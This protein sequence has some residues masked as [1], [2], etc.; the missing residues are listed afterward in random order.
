MSFPRDVEKS[1]L[2]IPSKPTQSTGDYTLLSNKTKNVYDTKLSNKGSFFNERGRTMRDGGTDHLRGPSG[3]SAN[4]SSRQ[5]S[6]HMASKPKALG[7]ASPRSGSLPGLGATD[8]T[9]QPPAITSLASKVSK[10]S[11]AQSLS[12][13]SKSSSDKTSRDIDTRTVRGAVGTSRSSRGRSQTIS[14]SS[15]AS[16]N[17]LV[18]GEPSNK[19]TRSASCTRL[20]FP[21]KSSQ[22]PLA[23]KEQGASLQ[24]KD[25]A[26][27]SQQPRPPLQSASAVN[28]TNEL[29]RKRKERSN[30][31]DENS[32]FVGLSTVE[33]NP[34]TS[35]SSATRNSNST[36]NQKR[37][38]IRVFRNGLVSY[39]PSRP[40]IPE[41]QARSKAPPQDLIVLGR[42]DKYVEKKAAKSTK[43]E[44]HNLDG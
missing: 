34:N 37:P 6:A 8:E 18:T 2:F 11:R 27:L 29:S 23:A 39:R 36:T 30:S 13:A 28:V 1:K 7:A 17:A 31:G 16:P 25:T 19:Q 10:R 9:T 44:S 33:G 22:Y 26:A 4:S 21:S 12:Q 38:K 24:R 40:S 32:S 3:T 20:P 43:K 14:G 15:S 41:P 42:V 35:T 5:N